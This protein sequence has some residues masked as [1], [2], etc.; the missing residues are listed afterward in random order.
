MTDTVSA[1]TF[2]SSPYVSPSDQQ[3]W[4]AASR[5]QRGM[6]NSFQNGLFVSNCREPG[7]RANGERNTFLVA[8]LQ[9]FRLVASTS[10]PCPR[11]P[12]QAGPH[13]V[14]STVGGDSRRCLRQE[15]TP[16]PAKPEQNVEVPGEANLLQLSVLSSGTTEEGSGGYH[17]IAVPCEGG[18]GGGPEKVRR[19]HKVT[20]LSTCQRPLS[21]SC[22]V[23][24]NEKH[25][26]WL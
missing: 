8:L 5:R 4:R 10:Q 3:G 25:S 9:G 20:Q 24:R 21:A 6:R 16:A 22:F 12:D 17:F 13:P 1:A 15:R 2:H 19:S 26:S 14:S 11:E 18:A 23:S 7:G